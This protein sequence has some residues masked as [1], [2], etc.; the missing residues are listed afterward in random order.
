[1]R[2]IDFCHPSLLLRAL[3]SRG[4]P[5]RHRGFHRGQLIDGPVALLALPVPNPTSPGILAF[6]DA[7]IASVDRQALKW[8]AFSARHVP[9]SRTSGIPVAALARPA[10]TLAFALSRR[11]GAGCQDRFHAALREEN[12]AFPAWN[13]FIRQAPF[14]DSR[15]CEHG[16]FGPSSVTLTSA[17]FD[18][19][20]VT[21][22]LTT[23]FRPSSPV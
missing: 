23:P 11:F 22:R 4:F 2:P 1:M 21:H 12:D 14:E 6:H 5:V 8:W 17:S 20:A 9:D 13:A 16:P 10:G 15:S 18:V 19:V 7:L 3:T